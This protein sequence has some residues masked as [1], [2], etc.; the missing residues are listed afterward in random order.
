MNFDE[1]YSNENP[2]NY[3]KRPAFPF[4]TAENIIPIFTTLSIL[5]KMRKELGL[6]AMLEYTEFYVQ[7]IEEHN[8]RFKGAVDQAL[9]LVSVKRIYGAMRPNNQKS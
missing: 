5:L 1:E 4:L 3:P 9:S 6:E 8:P 2:A 7:T